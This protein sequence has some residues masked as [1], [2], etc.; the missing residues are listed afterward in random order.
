M[1]FLKHS[2]DNITSTN[3]ATTNTIILVLIPVPVMC[4]EYRVGTD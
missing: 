4:I 2:S 1:W 3:I